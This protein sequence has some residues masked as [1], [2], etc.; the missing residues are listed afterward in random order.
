MFK[1]KYQ[2]ENSKAKREIRGTQV[3]RPRQII[4]SSCL[5]RLA[6]VSEGQ[7]ESSSMLYITFEDIHLIR[8][9]STF[10]ISLTRRRLSIFVKG[11]WCCRTR[12]A[13]TTILNC[14]HAVALPHCSHS[15]LCNG[16]LSRGIRSIQDS[17]CTFQGWD[18]SIGGVLIAANRLIICKDEG[19][20]PLVSERTFSD[21]NILID[22]KGLNKIASFRQ[23]EI[24][25]RVRSTFEAKKLKFPFGVAAL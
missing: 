17:V 5:I 10:T 8:P 2:I 21:H 18:C 3:E 1:K 7:L 13:P 6:R 23:L 20:T 24:L 14:K 4:E 15:A 16:V 12:S 19:D 22:W 11:L 25:W 9:R